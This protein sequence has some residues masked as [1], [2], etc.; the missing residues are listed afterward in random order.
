MGR[1]RRRKKRKKKQGQA[2]IPLIPCCPKVKSLGTVYGQFPLHRVSPT[3]NKSQG[4]AL[5]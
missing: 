2:Q 4:L 3:L 1:R 5:A